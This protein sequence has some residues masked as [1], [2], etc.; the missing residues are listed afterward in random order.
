MGE[1][2]SSDNWKDALFT[3]EIIQVLKSKEGSPKQVQG[4][5]E[6]GRPSWS[7][8][9]RAPSL[10]LTV[11]LLYCFLY[12]VFII[13]KLAYFFKNVKNGEYA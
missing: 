7:K 6:L 2:G 9:E 11:L 13:V 12:Y 1:E 3:I 4:Y 8:G 10:P 5:T